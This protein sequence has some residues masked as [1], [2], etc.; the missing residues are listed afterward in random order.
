MT[1][2]GSE[3]REDEVVRPD[4][5]PGIYGVVSSRNLA[6][7]AVPLFA[8]RTTRAAHHVGARS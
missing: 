4:W 1:T 7:G 6:L 5:Q 2:R 8:D 3:V